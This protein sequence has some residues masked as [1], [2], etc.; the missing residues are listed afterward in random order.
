[1]ILVSTLKKIKQLPLHLHQMCELSVL[2][3]LVLSGKAEDDMI[4]YHLPISYM[5]DVKKAQ[6]KNY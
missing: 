1:M 4:S 3:N 6:N 2:R 5:K